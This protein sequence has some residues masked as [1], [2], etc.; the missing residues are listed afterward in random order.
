MAL[1]LSGIPVIDNHCH[2]CS[3][4]CLPCGPWLVL[5]QPATN[6]AAPCILDLPGR[7]IPPL[8][9]D[10]APTPYGPS[11]SNSLTMA[12]PERSTATFT[13]IRFL[14][15]SIFLPTPSGTK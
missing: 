11:S 15:C 6:A 5:E 14:C 9:L 3:P 1:D 10:P 12:L 8:F 7:R 2:P 13:L 4:R